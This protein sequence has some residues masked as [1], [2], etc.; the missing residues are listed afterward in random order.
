MAD[1]KSKILDHKDFIRDCLQRGRQRIIETMG[2]GDYGTALFA[3]T[4]YSAI[5]RI[6][7]E[8]GEKKGFTDLK[9][10]I[11]ILIETDFTENYAQR[12]GLTVTPENKE[13][14]LR[15]HSPHYIRFIELINHTK[16]II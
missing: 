8:E 16:Q 12:L 13:N 3:A 11:E 2:R 7:K 5:A 6:E 14:L 9:S 15:E 1:Y 10:R 4:V